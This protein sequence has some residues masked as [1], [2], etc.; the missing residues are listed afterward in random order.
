MARE[1]TPFWVLQSRKQRIRRLKTGMRI[2]WVAFEGP[3]ALI[4]MSETGIPVKVSLQQWEDL[5]HVRADTGIEMD[6]VHRI[7][8]SYPN[9]I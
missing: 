8:H 5:A 7:L 9:P 4:R 2:V 1:Y 3:K 6:T